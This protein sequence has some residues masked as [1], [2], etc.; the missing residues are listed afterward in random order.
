MHRGEQQSGAEGEVIDEVI[1]AELEE[2]SLLRLTIRPIVR[3]FLPEPRTV[4]RNGI[5]AGGDGDAGEKIVGRGSQ[6]RM[7]LLRIRVR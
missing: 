6:E 5:H 4:V 2:A 3:R 7:R 1:E